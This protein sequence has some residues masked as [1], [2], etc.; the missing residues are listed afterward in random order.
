MAIEAIL[1]TLFGWEDEGEEVV[2]E[3]GP[4][5]GIGAEKE[6]GKGMREFVAQNYR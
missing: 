5:L 6:K 1:G 2:E 4:L 3:V